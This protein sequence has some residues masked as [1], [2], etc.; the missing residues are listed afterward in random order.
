MKYLTI[1]VLAATLSGCGSMKL[2][3]LQSQVDEARIACDSD[4]LKDYQFRNKEY[5]V[6]FNCNHVVIM[7]LRQQQPQLYNQH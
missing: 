4:K 2:F 7:E 6:S 3:N 1:V 5:N